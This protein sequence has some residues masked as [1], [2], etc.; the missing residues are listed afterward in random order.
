MDWN[1][2]TIIWI[3]NPSTKKIFTPFNLT[4]VS[5]SG[6][7][8]M[9]SLLNELASFHRSNSQIVGV[10]N[11]NIK[12]IQVSQKLKKICWHRFN[13]VHIIDFSMEAIRFHLFGWHLLLYTCQMTIFSISDV[14]F[15]TKQWV[16]IAL[17]S[18][19]VKLTWLC[20]LFCARLNN[21]NQ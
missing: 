5:T 1:E 20:S 7:S 21:W 18:M 13:F 6:S 19:S 14:D 8:S 11:G 15:F 4:I 10:I 12:A 3:E 17:T 9:Q 16:K 2:G